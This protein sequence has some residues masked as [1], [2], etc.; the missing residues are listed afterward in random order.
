MRVGPG[1]LLSG[2]VGAVTNRLR[3]LIPAADLDER[4]TDYIRETLPGLW[5]LASLYFRADVRGLHHIQSEGPVLLV[6]NHSGGM[7]APDMFVF[8]LA[9]STYFG[10]ER[11]FYS[12]TE[13]QALP[14]IPT[15]TGLDGQTGRVDDTLRVPN[16]PW[17]FAIGDVNERSRS[18]AVRRSRTPRVAAADRAMQRRAPASVQKPRDEV[19]VLH[20]AACGEE[21]VTHSFLR[22]SPDRTG[23]LGLLEQP[24][25]RLAVG[26]QLGRLLEQNP[27]PAVDNLVLDASDSRSDDRTSLPH[28]L[29]DGE[30]ES[31]SDALLHDHVGPPLKRV[32]DRRVLLEVVH[33]QARQVH[34]LAGVA[35]DAREVTRPSSC[36]RARS[37]ADRTS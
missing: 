8:V 21:L 28:R 5:A 4:D 26:G 20:Q 24:P 18:E 19:E 11:R 35:A 15:A 27:A 10:V 30:S 29:R 13:P 31:L 9:F 23:A 12:R 25:H 16:L 36:W 33:R 7:V 34:A 3:S 37:A 14:N 22:L 2:A 32:H 1:G 17:L 6:G